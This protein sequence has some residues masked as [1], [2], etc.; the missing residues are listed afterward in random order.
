[1]KAALLRLGMACSFLI[2]VVA[3]EDSKTTTAPGALAQ[4]RFNAPDSARSGQAFTVDV[5][6]LNIGINGVHNG[7]VTVTLPAPLTVNSV[8][9]SPGTSAVFSNGSGATVTWTLNTLDSNSQSTLH[10]NTIG[11][12]PGATPGMTL[13]LRAELTADGVGAGEAVAEANVS[14]MP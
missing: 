4:V 13:T 1:M 14:L 7:R 5:A 2:G 6:A 9:S 12:L 8:D 10:I 3:C 11:I